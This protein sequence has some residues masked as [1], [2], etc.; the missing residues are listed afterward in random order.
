MK[1]IENEVMVKTIETVYEAIDGK[2]FDSEEACK[3]W[4]KSYECTVKA[5]WDKIPKQEINSCDFGLTYAEEEYDCFMVIPRNLN[6][7]TTINAFVYM[8]TH[9]DAIM[10]AENI[11]KVMVLNFGYD[12]DWCDVYEMENRL[13]FLNQMWKKTAE[14]LTNV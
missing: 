14:K 3:K 6:D 8:H 11:G 5:S 9:Q 4:E 7:I 2:R 10:S 13:A 12:Y 1:K